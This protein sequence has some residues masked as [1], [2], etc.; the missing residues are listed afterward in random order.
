[1]E[2]AFIIEVLD[3]NDAPFSIQMTPT[4]GQVSFP[5]NT[6]RV[7]ENSPLNTIIGTLVGL[8]PDLNQQLSFQLDDDASG[9]FVL[10]AQSKCLAVTNIQ[11]YNTQCSTLLK[12]NGP[13][14]YEKTK[15]FSI[16]VRVTDTHGSFTTQQL[17]VT[18]IDQNDPPTNITLSGSIVNENS[19]GALIGAFTTLDED[20]SQSYMYSLIDDASGRF[21]VQGS[22][23]YASSNANLDFENQT[24]YKITVQVKDTGSPPLN[25]TKGF[26][27]TVRDINEAPTSFNLTNNF[28]MENS[29]PGTV[30][31]SLVV[32]DP[33]NLG[34]NGTVQTHVCS[35]IGSQVG[36]FVV[37]SNVLKLGSAAVNFE[38]ASIINVDIRCTDNGNPPLSLSKTEQVIVGD[39][40]EAPSNISLSSNTIAEN[41]S[42]SLVGKY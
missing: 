2:K 1:M 14:N 5:T 13:L 9:Q 3:V 15:D 28:V 21:D 37:Q 29:N 24:A 42:P 40:N 36:K 18:V 23:L 33:D 20:T 26:S 35:V 34:P 19:N 27:I 32:R 39:V 11:G 10:D 38:Q 25:F 31:G 12:L 17:T 7:K 30:I 4:N 6:P 22:K 41:T 8:D 16:I